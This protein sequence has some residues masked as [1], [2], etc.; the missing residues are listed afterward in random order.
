MATSECLA[1]LPVCLRPRMALTGR[2]LGAG[3]MGL[4]LASCAV[5]PN[6][7]G[8]P[9]ADVTGYV[10]GELASPQAS[11][12]SPRVPPQRF[13]TGAEISQRWWNAFH[14]QPLDDL[15][16]ISVEQSP[17]LQAAEAAIKVAQFNA[18]AQRGL[19]FPQIGVNYTP[20]D[21]Q[22][23]NMVR[24][25]PTIHPQQRYSLQTAQ[26]TISFVPD[27]WGQNFRSVESLD[28][29]TEQQYF[30]L[31][32]AYLTL[33]TQVVAAAI[34][35][36]SLRSQID[37]TRR[38]IKIER[39]ILEIL[40][41]QFSAGQAA[42]VDVLTQEA[43]LAQVEQTLPPLEK[44][45]AVQRNLLTALAGQFSA[46]E[47]LQKFELRNLRLPTNL[48]V[49]LPS[50]LVRQRPDVRAAEA[51]M[52]SASALVGVAVAARLPNITLSANP[53][54]SA[55][56]FA[57]MFT[58]GT[59]FYTVAASATHTVFDGL[60]L[61]H[62]Q[63]AAEAALEQANALYRQAV[64]TAFQ[65]VADAL[66]GLQADARSVQAAIKAEKA[67]QASLDIVRKQLVLGQI[68][69]VTVLN[70]QQTYFNAAISRVQAEANRLTD[71]AALFMALGGGWPTDCPST[72]WRGCVFDTQD[73][74]E[75]R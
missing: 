1:R 21:Q 56:N 29:V 24:S 60:S 57:Q 62:K 32:A 35:E 10:R 18:L 72:D 7:Y 58:P 15:V 43:A 11:A 44:A 67:A 16:R 69:Q 6:F 42:Q 26:L 49:S 47:I 2:V 54:T 38:I 3:V 9:E 63:K 17:S 68:N 23:S 70:A 45:L 65:N 39:D 52:H 19:Y 59:M 30:E 36:A 64:I 46:D 20:S 61:Y 25:D 75:F 73:G 41:N 4:V 74:P 53:G 37:A 40:R 50:T 27:I 22:L 34:Q 51:N 55:V 12:G 33:T 31:E 48:P 66:R 28:A 8:P 13:A 71:T 5:G 14:S